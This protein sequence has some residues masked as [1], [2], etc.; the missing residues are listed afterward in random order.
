MRDNHDGTQNSLFQ[1]NRLS[2][3]VC[4][5][6]LLLCFHCNRRVSKLEQASYLQDL[7]KSHR[8]FVVSL[9][10]MNR[11]NYQL[12]KSIGI[13]VKCLNVDVMYHFYRLV[14]YLADCT[15]NTG[16]AIM[17]SSHSFQVTFYRPENAVSMVFVG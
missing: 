6:Y 16:M 7:L 17:K 1:N 3:Q 4:N 12:E 2:E 9:Q 8:Y 15:Q 14:S 5:L 10:P 11:S 13:N